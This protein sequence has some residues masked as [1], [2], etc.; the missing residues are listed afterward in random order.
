MGSGGGDD[1][2]ETIII[3]SALVFTAVVFGTAFLCAFIPTKT[4]VEYATK[5]AAK[6]R[7]LR[8]ILK[9]TRAVAALIKRDDHQFGGRR[10]SKVAPELTD[11]EATAAAKRGLKKRKKRIEEL[12][13]ASY[14]PGMA[15]CVDRALDAE[16]NAMYEQGLRLFVETTSEDGDDDGGGDDDEEAPFIDMGEVVGAEALEAFPGVIRLRREGK[17]NVALEL[18]NFDPGMFEKAGIGSEP[19][20][21][22]LNE[23]EWELCGDVGVFDRDMFGRPEMYNPDEKHPARQGFHPELL[24]I[25]Q[26]LTRAAVVAVNGTVRNISI[27]S[28]IIIHAELSSRGGDSPI[29]LSSVCIISCFISLHR[30]TSDCVDVDVQ[31]VHGIP[32]VRRRRCAKRSRYTSSAVERTAHVGERR[33]EPTMNE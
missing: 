17:G 29:T 22:D 20:W 19:L 28:S 5:Y 6:S 25:L 4:L 11:D 21:R 12:G 3:S 16:G 8:A 26:L 7:A 24:E 18:C 32:R 15:W 27:G 1:N 13:L 31:N 23:K 10:K 9:L 2:L 30:Y 14:T 33:K